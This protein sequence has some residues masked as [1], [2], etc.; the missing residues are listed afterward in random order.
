MYW[1]GMATKLGLPWNTAQTVDSSLV[2]PKC[3]FGT[4][5]V[6]VYH[7]PIHTDPWGRETSPPEAWEDR[8]LVTLAF[9]LR[10]WGVTAKGPGEGEA[11]AQVYKPPS[12]ILHQ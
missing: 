6:A 7:V 9:L 1:S 5:C 4:S 2:R 12:P 11:Q 8:V 3:A 10:A